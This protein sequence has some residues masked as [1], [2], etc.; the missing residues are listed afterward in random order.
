MVSLVCYAMATSLIVN[1]ALRLI[2]TA[3]GFWRGVA[4]MML[5]SLITAATHLVQI[6]LWAVVF[7]MCGELA[8]FQ[9]AFYYSAQ[10]YTSLGYGDVR[11][12]ERWQLLG[13]LEAVNGLLLFGLSTAIMFAVLSRLI[14]KRLHRE[15]DHLG[16][17][18]SAF[19]DGVVTS[20]AL[21]GAG[22]LKKRSRSGTAEVRRSIAPDSASC[23]SCFAAS[24]LPAFPAAGLVA[25]ANNNLPDNALFPVHPGL[26][27]LAN[28]TRRIKIGPPLD[29]IDISFAMGTALEI[30]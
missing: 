27:C 24:R 1:L 14:A 4:I 19:D 29:Q 15:I 7:L 11:L 18:E 30:A 12:S 21:D 3:S 28:L 5:V 17:D 26:V 23:R 9:Q 2:R 25:A 16:M 13:P 6:G 10:N 20:P 8:S 22:P